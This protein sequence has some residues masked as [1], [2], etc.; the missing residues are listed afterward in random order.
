MGQYDIKRILAYSTVSQLGLMMAGLGVGGVSAGMFHLLTHAFFKALL[1]LGAGSIIHGFSGEQDIRKL[2]GVARAM[3]LTSVCYLCGMLALCAFPYTAGYYS[4]D[5][6][7]AEAYETSPAVFWLVAL[8]ALLTSFYMTRQCCYLFIGKP[9]SAPAH[10]PHESPLVMTLPLALLAVFALF[11]GAVATHMGLPE[12][13]DSGRPLPPHS[14]FV[15]LVSWTASLCGILIGFLVYRTIGAWH[16]D[17]IRAGLLENSFYFDAL[18]AVTVGRLW[19]FLA[20]LADLFDAAM[21]ILT[22]C[23]VYT[24]RLVAGIIA[25][26]GD[27]RWIDHYA[28]DGTSE[29]VRRLGALCTLPQS[30]FLPSYLRWV[31]GGVTVLG[32]ILY[33]QLA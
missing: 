17:L 16:S 2:G 22:E 10:P 15:T 32:L 20:L 27:R 26:R 19:R 24:A 18:Y 5:L 23:F 21:F 30:G 31:T 3:P 1:F 33:W 8:S 9:R 12:Y 25:W 13:L 6:I 7:L 28:F 14:E 29:A 4:K 11:G